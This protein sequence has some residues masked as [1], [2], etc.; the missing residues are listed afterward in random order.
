M[1]DNNYPHIENT[2]IVAE[3]SAVA[4][5]PTIYD[6]VISYLHQTHMPIGT[7]RAVYRQLQMEVADE[8][9]AYMKRRLKEFRKLEPDWDADGAESVIPQI[10]DFVESLLRSCDVHEL[11]DWALFPNVNGTL[12]LQHKDA[13]ISIGTEEFSY[14]AE[15]ENKAIGHDHQPLSLEAVKSTIETINRY[16]R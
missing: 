7:K 13:A 8:N 10:A 14:F 3:E 5:T 1:S 12:L 4:Y 2:P 9:L 16:V 11:T 6:T 15:K